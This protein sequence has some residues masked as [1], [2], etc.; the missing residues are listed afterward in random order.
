MHSLLSLLVLG[1]NVIFD[2]YGYGLLINNFL[3]GLHCI[4]FSGVPFHK[5]YTI[6]VLFQKS[7]NFC[8]YRIFLLLLVKNILSSVL[9][10]RIRQILRNFQKSSEQYSMSRFCFLVSNSYNL[11][12]PIENDQFWQISIFANTVFSRLNQSKCWKI[13]R[14][15]SKCFEN[16]IFALTTLE[17][18]KCISDNVCDSNILTF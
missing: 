17:L 8:N 15:C 13:S 14:I 5:G 7:G 4:Y 6:K 12:S 10:F 18:W 3:L 2:R 11:L 16:F 1:L 9:T